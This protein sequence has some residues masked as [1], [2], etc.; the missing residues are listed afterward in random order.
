MPCHVY[1]HVTNQKPAHKKAEALSSRILST[2]EEI[3]A[4]KMSKMAILDLINPS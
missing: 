3:Y 2:Y 4:C 1:W